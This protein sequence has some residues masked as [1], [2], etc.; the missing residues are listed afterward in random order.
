MLVVHHY[1]H[2]VQ[3]FLPEEA[4]LLYSQLQLPADEKKG[5]QRQRQMDLL[6]IDSSFSLP[7][8]AHDTTGEILDTIRM[9][10]QELTH[11]TFT[12]IIDI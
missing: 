4:G 12:I 11:K 2:D 1:L 10:I 3:K 6:I 5:L 8:L 7:L 9:C